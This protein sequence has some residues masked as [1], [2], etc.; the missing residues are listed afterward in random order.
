MSEAEEYERVRQEHIAAKAAERKEKLQAE[1]E[2]A[3]RQAQM[4]SE[5]NDFDI[6]LQLYMEEQ[7]AL[8]EQ[9]QLLAAA[10]AGFDCPI[11]ME[12]WSIG[13]QSKID[14]CG[15]AICRTCMVSAVK[16][17]LESRRWPVT[18]PLCVSSPPENG[19]PGGKPATDSLPELNRPLSCNS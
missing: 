14:S 7:R 5:R 1:K 13:M 17:V 8:A 9:A 16:A 11:C 12:T 18:C 6:A 2:R 19:E 10:D 15:H 4:E 3:Q